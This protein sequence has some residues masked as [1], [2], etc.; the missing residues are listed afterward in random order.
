MSEIESLR[1]EVERLAAIVLGQRLDRAQVAE[2]LRVDPHTVSRWVRQ[3][4][5]PAPVGGYWM[6]GIIVE[7]ELS[8]STRNV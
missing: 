7:W 3:G 8:Q 5:L 2:R 1:R 6:L 4:R